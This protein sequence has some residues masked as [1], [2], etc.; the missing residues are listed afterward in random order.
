[1][2]TIAR[3]AT[4]TRVTAVSITLVLG[5]GI[6]GACS[7]GDDRTTTSAQNT[8]T[9][10][11]GSSP[12]NQLVNVKDVKAVSL[13]LALNEGVPAG[14]KIGLLVSGTGPGNDVFGQ[15]TGAYI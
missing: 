3:R 5:A 10:A 8:S 14:T 6:I 2:T 4:I 7:N 11:Q 15:A 9:T 13:P 12:A 1:M